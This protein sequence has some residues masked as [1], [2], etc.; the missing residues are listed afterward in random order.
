MEQNLILTNLVIKE[1]FVELTTQQY[2]LMLQATLNITEGLDGRDPNDVFCSKL[3]DIASYG[4]KRRPLEEPSLQER[5]Q[6]TSLLLQYFELREMLN[7][8]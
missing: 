7:K 2:M 8:E 6:Q 1:G 4:V 5:M 3:K